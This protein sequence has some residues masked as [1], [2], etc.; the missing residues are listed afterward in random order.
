MRIAQKMGGCCFFRLIKSQA[1]RE[2]DNYF[3]L[4]A[5]VRRSR[6]K[7]Y[8]YF[9]EGNVEASY[10]IKEKSDTGIS[11]HDTKNSNSCR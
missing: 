10:E 4:P 1:E 7:V 11:K 3:S 2:R 9:S 5:R 6:I 8:R